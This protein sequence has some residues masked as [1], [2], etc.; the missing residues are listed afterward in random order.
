MFY[1]H[2]WSVFSSN[3][4]LYWS[5]NCTLTRISKKMHFLC[6]NTSLMLCFS[7]DS[8]V[9]EGKAMLKLRLGL[10][11]L[12]RQLVQGRWCWRSLLFNPTKRLRPN[13]NKNTFVVSLYDPFLT[14]WI[15]TVY[16]EQHE[17]Q[18]TD[19][20]ALVLFLCF[21]CLPICQMLRVSGVQQ[22]PDE[23]LW[24][25]FLSK[26]I[27]AFSHFSCS[28]TFRCSAQNLAVSLSLSSEVSASHCVSLCLVFMPSS[29]FHVSA[30]HS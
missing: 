24:S 7:E 3:Q 5:L 15:R 16:V 19:K 2:S 17:L 22:R 26:V 30:A 1:V 12:W 23:R 28:V 18:H 14:E 13:R 20:L 4:Q 11:G 6:T 25:G 21:I 10:T 27:D 9:F 8:A 29:L